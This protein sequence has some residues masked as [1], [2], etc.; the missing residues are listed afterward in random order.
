MAFARRALRSQ[1]SPASSAS[2]CTATNRIFDGSCISVFRRYGRPRAAA[3]LSTTTA[4]PNSSPI[5]VPP[6]ETTSTPTSVVIA[7][8][9]TSRAAA[10]L[11]SR[12]PSTWTSSPSSWARSQIAA[13]SS[14][15]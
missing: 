14:G 12:A 9:G 11:V 10:A 4:S 3:G 7:R 5:L 6:N 2:N 8:S 15:V 1:R 13:S